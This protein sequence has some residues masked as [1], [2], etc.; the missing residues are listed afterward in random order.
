MF[1][2]YLIILLLVCL[3]IFTLVLF[4]MHILRQR[5]HKFVYVCS[6]YRAYDGRSVKDNVKV[7]RLYCR[8]IAK[9]GFVPVA[10]H[11]FFPQFLED[12][13]T[14]ERKEGLDLALL[15]LK[16]CQKVYVFKGPGD[17]TSQGMQ[18]EI[19]IAH[20][21]RIEVIDGFKAGLKGGFGPGT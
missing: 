7:A 12:G 4:V 5:K 10:P 15:M 1:E 8:Y 17:Y 9:A 11:L 16:S 20:K 6:P 19:E 18:T 13:L 2:P 21:L 14:S 3:N